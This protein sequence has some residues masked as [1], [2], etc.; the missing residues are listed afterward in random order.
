[1][2][3]LTA[4]E[5]DTLT[6]TPLVDDVIDALG[7]DPR[8]HYVETYWL[9]TLGP[10]TTWLLRRLVAGFDTEPEGYELSLSATATALGLGSKGGRH[11]PFVRALSRCVQFDMAQPHGDTGLAVRRKIPPLNRRQVQRLP[12]ALQESHA[13]W[14]Q[15][16]LEMPLAQQQ[17][18]RA[19]HLALSLLELGEEPELA[20]RQLLR[21][22][23][24]PAMAREAMAWAVQRHQAAL[25]AATAARG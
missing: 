25:A 20:E 18:Q 4:L 13:R 17:R 7:H 23:Y 8:S 2:S 1:M 10:S 16:Q 24:Q 15:E 14:Q 3:L 21:W 19:R 22:R 12:P 6:V 9:G 11:S 5:T